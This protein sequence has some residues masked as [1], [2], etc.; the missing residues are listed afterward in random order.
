MTISL[1]PEQ[2]AWIA[3][4]VATG[5]FSSPENA[6][7]QLIDESIAARAEIELGDLAWVKPQVDEAMVE[8][9]RGEIMTREE[10]RR[11]LLAHPA[12]KD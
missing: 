9:D 5:D 3:A 11:R 8:V 6:A 4:H 12:L 7:R 2:Q 10:Y 1:T